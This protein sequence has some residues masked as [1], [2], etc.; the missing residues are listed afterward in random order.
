MT[1]KSGVGAEWRFVVRCKASLE[2]RA[3][4]GKQV[5]ERRE[6]V[7]RCPVSSIMSLS[8]AWTAAALNFLQYFWPQPSSLEVLR[9]K[10]QGDIIG[11][12][13]K[14]GALWCCMLWWVHSYCANLF[15]KCFGECCVVGFLFCFTSPWLAL[16]LNLSG[17]QAY[18]QGQSNS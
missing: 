18:L 5:E 17:S 4:Q 15:F 10:N 16:L 11:N 6:A 2:G 13:T 14:W 3:R 8:T 1:E 7:R 12:F 9:I